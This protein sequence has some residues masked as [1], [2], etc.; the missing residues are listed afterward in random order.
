M[1]RDHLIS[2]GSGVSAVESKHK[3][4]CNAASTASNSAI[5]QGESARRNDTV[6]SDGVEKLLRQEHDSANSRMRILS[7]VPSR[8]GSFPTTVKTRATTLPPKAMVEG[9][10]VGAWILY[11]LMD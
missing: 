6:V 3:A 2:S 7:N 9:E 8:R 5:G 11:Y 4:A 10:L 1:R